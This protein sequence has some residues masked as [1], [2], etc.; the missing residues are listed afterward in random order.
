MSHPI[1]CKCEAC[2]FMF[3]EADDLAAA[4]WKSLPRCKR[5]GCPHNNCL[6][7]AAGKCAG[8]CN[9]APTPSEPSP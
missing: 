5:P 8:G 9:C 1:D 7:D 2:A 4:L 3:K 6:F